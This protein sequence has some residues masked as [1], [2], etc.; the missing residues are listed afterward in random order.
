[1][2]E[3]AVR[4]NL[5]QRS[6]EEA[7]LVKLII[8]VIGELAELLGLLVQEVEVGSALIGNVTLDGLLNLLLVPLDLS[9]PVVLLIVLITLVVKSKVGLSRDLL[10]DY[11]IVSIGFKFMPS[12]NRRHTL[13]SSRQCLEQPCNALQQPRPALLD[14]HG[15]VSRLH[16]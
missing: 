3:H 2:L 7:F 6:L 5:V 10:T 8:V 14:A 1:M 16:S 15:D 9:V 13:K 4:L 11:M 12:Y